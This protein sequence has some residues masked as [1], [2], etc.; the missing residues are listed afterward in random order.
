MKIKSFLV[1][2]SFMSMILFDGCVLPSYYDITYVNNADYNINFQVLDSRGKYTNCYPDTTIS[3]DKNMGF[4]K[5]GSYV[6]VVI[7][8]LT[9][10]EFVFNLPSDT[11]SVFYFHPDTLSKYSWEVIQNDYKILRRYDLSLEDLI[12]LKDKY[13]VPVIPYPPTEVMKDMK[14]YPPY[15]Q[16][17]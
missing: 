12:K 3:F 13:D 11:L 2:L 9:I 16:Q 7:G 15:E 10:E 6:D 5:A 17:K 1:I 8:I 14:M 4:I